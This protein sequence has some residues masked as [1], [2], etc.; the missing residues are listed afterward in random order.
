MNN[1]ILFAFGL[2]IVTYSLTHIYRIAAIALRI[3]DEPNERSAHEQ[4]TPTGAGIVFVVI[5][6]MAVAFFARGDVVPPSIEIILGVLPALLI[7]AVVGLVDDFRPMSWWFRLLIHIATAGWVTY[8]LNFQLLES[9]GWIG[10]LL[11]AVG[12]VWM[13]N[14][15]NFMDGIDGI[16]ASETLFVLLGVSFITWVQVNSLNTALISLV[17]VC[18]GFLV[19]NWPKARVFMGDAGSKFL[20]LSLGVFALSESDVS[21]WTWL[22]LL[23]WFWIDATLT[24]GVRLIR[25]EKV[26]HAHSQH[27]Y[28]HLNRAFGTQKTLLVVHLVN[29]LWLFPM[30]VYS[31]FE[32]AVGSILVLLV[33]IPLV[34]GIYL[35]GAGQ[36]TPKVKAPER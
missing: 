22:I 36:E 3:V 17:G 23:A 7:V 26:Q 4:S 25:G 35:L 1:L 13:L 2:A 10:L 19:I 8:F 34:P 29:L 31:T 20:G 11:G 27:A 33:A 28:Q 32:P 12:L 6:S 21:L 30:A 14:L 18:A 16:A 5:F 15:Y 24:L 9:I